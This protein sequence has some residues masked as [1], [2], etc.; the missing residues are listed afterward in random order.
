MAVYQRL[1]HMHAHMPELAKTAFLFERG[2]NDSSYPDTYIYKEAGKLKRYY[3]GTS[4]SGEYSSRKTDTEISREAA[5]K[6]TISAMTTE[7][8]P[9]PENCPGRW[10]E[11]SQ[12]LDNYMNGVSE[13]PFVD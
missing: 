2:G 5:I 7:M 3:T 1:H 12:A 11:V 6:A 8:F 13:S 9:T 10:Q 4:W